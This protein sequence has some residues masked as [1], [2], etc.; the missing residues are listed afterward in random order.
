MSLAFCKPL[1][2]G[3]MVWG[4][5]R[6]RVLERLKRSPWPSLTGFQAILDV[7]SLNSIGAKERCPVPIVAAVLRDRRC[8]GSKILARYLYRQLRDCGQNGRRRYRGLFGD[9]LRAPGR[10]IHRRH[11]NQGRSSDRR[12]T[13][14]SCDCRSASFGFL[15]CGNS[16]AISKISINCR[17]YNA[18][19]NFGLA[20]YF[21]SSSAKFVRKEET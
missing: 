7:Q 19:R 10:S 11:F 2:S 5:F 20:I 16:S 18:D 9:Y 15:I 3:G 13:Q 17:N 4:L 6:E 1:I 8:A 14:Y 21:R 12:P